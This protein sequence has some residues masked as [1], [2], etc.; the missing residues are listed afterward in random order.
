MA[1]SLRSRPSE[2]AVDA[3]RRGAH[4]SRPSAVLAILP[5]VAVIAVIG[6]LAALLYSLLIK[7]STTVSSAPGSLDPGVS[8]AASASAGAP[9]SATPGAGHSSAPSASPSVAARAGA[10]PKVSVNFYNATTTKGLSRKAAT[11]A[12]TVGWRIGSIQSWRGGP[13]TET[14]VYVAHEAQRADGQALVAL[15]KVGVVKVSPSR[16]GAGGISVVVGPDYTPQG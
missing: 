5:V 12:Q 7:P 10:D 2:G 9:A 16:A 1:Q 15:L 6:A 4:R 14:V 8:A 11:V 3:S 13:V